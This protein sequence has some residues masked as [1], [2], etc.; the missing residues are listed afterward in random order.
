LGILE[1]QRSATPGSAIVS[2]RQGIRDAWAS[3]SIVPKEVE[4]FAHWI[5]GGNE[6]IVV[7]VGHSGG[8]IAFGSIAPK[9]SEL[10]ALYVTSE[11]GGRGTG[12]AILGRLE[13]LARNA[14]TT[15]LRMN[16]SISAVPFYEANGFISLGCGL[17]AMPYGGRMPYVRMRKYL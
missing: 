13:V 4:D 6:V 15:E 5:G 11:H 7:A 14:G 9:K 3:A 12:R 17:H 2:Y 10:R 1:A 8:I 16:A